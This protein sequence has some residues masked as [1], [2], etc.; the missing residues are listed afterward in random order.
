MIFPKSKWVGSQWC[1]GDGILRIYTWTCCSAIVYSSTLAVCFFV[2]F[3]NMNDWYDTSRSTLR[4]NSRVSS[5]KGT[6]SVL[7]HVYSLNPLYMWH[8]GH[9][10]TWQVIC[11]ASV[12]YFGDLDICN[13]FWHGSYIFRIIAIVGAW[14]HKWYLNNERC[15]QIK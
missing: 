13:M 11:Q 7:R 9:Y 14:N 5:P 6:S 2:P 4:P 12:L 1:C 8:K 15:V 10:C 3:R